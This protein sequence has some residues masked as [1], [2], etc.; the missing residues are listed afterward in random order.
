MRGQEASN[1]RMPLR[2]DMPVE[3]L[4]VVIEDSLYEVEVAIDRLIDRLRWLEL[5]WHRGGWNDEQVSR[6]RAIGRSIHQIWNERR[7]RV[8]QYAKRR[9]KKWARGWRPERGAKYPASAKKEPS[10]GRPQAAEI[11]E[12]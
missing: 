12:Y 10:R 6:A 5:V 11:V 7:K 9:Q 3:E 4:P 8:Q 2:C 1:L